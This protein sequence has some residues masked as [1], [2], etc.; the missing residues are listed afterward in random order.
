MHDRLAPAPK[1]QRTDRYRANHRLTG[2]FP[3]I[4]GRRGPRRF[5][6]SVGGGDIGNQ[7]GGR[8]TRAVFNIGVSLFETAR[9]LHFALT[10]GYL[11]FFV[12]HIGQVV[13]TGWNN[14]RSMVTGYEIVPVKQEAPRDVEHAA[15]A[16]HAP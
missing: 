1:R 2:A 13:K 3:R 12:I 7:F 5:E 4:A 9:I 8:P 15:T 10:I 6:S 16:V 14:F 11:V